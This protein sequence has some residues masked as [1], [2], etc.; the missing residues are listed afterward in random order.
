MAPPS[1][2]E[3]DL[4]KG[5]GVELDDEI[6]IEKGSIRRRFFTGKVSSLLGVAVVATRLTYPR[7]EENTNCWV[8]HIKD[9]IP[10]DTDQSD[11]KEMYVVTILKLL[12]ASISPVFSH[13]WLPDGI[14]GRA[15]TAIGGTRI[16][17]ILV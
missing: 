6:S 2:F 1:D 7:T 15:K 9:F 16:H 5:L 14:R 10:S 17:K 4:E 8:K 13:Q 12:G 11:Q 3:V